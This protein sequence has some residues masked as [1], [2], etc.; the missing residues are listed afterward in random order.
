MQPR[1]QGGEGM[2]FFQK[3][4]DGIISSFNL[5]KAKLKLDT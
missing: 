3:K 2:E 5:T 4:L 1:G